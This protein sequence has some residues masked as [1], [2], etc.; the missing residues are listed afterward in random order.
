MRILAIADEEARYYYDYY[1]PGKLDEIDLIL[2]CGDLKREYLEF[3]ITMGHCPVLYVR[4]NHDDS[5]AER[6]PEGCI[7]IEDQIY[8]YQGVR[9]L[10]L[11]GSHKYR[12]GENMYTERQMRWRVAKLWFQLRRYKGFDILLTH[13]PARNLNDF[14]SMSHRGFQC[15]G[16]LLEKY[17]P[18]YFIHGHI[19]K[20]YGYKIPRLTKHGKTTVINAWE[21]YKFDY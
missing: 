17:E 6:P 19:H 3:L 2:A 15:F 21:Y 10:G 18:K 13:A 11:G 1:T 16:E 7:C 12:D 9:I 8:V 20:N 5:F 4:G 14:D